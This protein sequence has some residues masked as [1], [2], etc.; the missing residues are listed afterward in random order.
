MGSLAAWRLASA[1]DTSTTRTHRLTVF[2]HYQAR[3]NQIT[4]AGITFVSLDGHHSVCRVDASQFIPG[5][6]E[7]DVALVFNKTYQLGRV[8]SELHQAMKPSGLVLCFQNGIGSDRLLREQNPGITIAEGILFEG[9]TLSKSG[10]V[11]HK[12]TGATWVS[13]TP[14]AEARYGELLSLLR[15]GGFDLRVQPDINPIQ[16]TKLAA[17][18]AINPLTAITGLKNKAVAE[19]SLLRS[20]ASA[21]AEEATSVSDQIHIRREGEYFDHILNVARNTGEN[22]SS[23]LRDIQQGRETE[24]QYINGTI[25]ELG[26]QLGIP[27]PANQLLL[28]LVTSYSGS[29]VSLETLEKQWLQSVSDDVM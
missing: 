25:V 12:G 10:E 7:I 4:E 24:V 5:Q 1:L 6:Q 20:I 15:H 11:H 28:D 14:D 2:G 8:A 13:L 9:V 29:S 23:M 16:W 17:N 3:L 27:T 21:V 18:A 22:T 19:H 26:K